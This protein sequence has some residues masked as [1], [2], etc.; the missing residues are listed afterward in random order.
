MV[1]AGH[2]SGADRMKVWP[3][4]SVCL[5]VKLKPVPESIPLVEY[6]WLPQEETQGPSVKDWTKGF[7]SLPG[8][9]GRQKT[10]CQA[11][12]EAPTESRC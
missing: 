6:H 3:H 7:S 9:L 12:G 8:G 5:S 11:K 10:G 2:D 1:A 4:A